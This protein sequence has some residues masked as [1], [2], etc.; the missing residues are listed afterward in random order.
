[1]KV[2][3]ELEKQQLLEDLQDDEELE[4]ENNLNESSGSQE[5]GKEKVVANK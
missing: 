3:Y 4:G 1:M 5:E 2:Y